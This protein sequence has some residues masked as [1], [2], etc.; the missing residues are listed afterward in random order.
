MSNP[1][2]NI[3]VLDSFELLHE[4]DLIHSN[5]DLSPGSQASTIIDKLRDRDVNVSLY[6]GDYEYLSLYT[7]KIT[8]KSAKVEWN[9]NVDASTIKEAKIKIYTYDGTLDNS[10]SLMYIKMSTDLVLS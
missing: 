1:F 7:T 6:E 2:T 8:D 3:D 10:V 5:L 9:G 4:V